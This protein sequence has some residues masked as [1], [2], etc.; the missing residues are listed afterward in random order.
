MGNLLRFSPPRGIWDRS[1]QGPRIGVTGCREEGLCRRDLDDL[2]EIHDDDA[3]RQHPH[4]IEVVGDEEVA[5]RQPFAEIGQQSEDDGLDRHIERRC[6]L[7]QDQERGLDR[8][9]ACDPDA[10]ALAA[11]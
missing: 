3:H 4:H 7:V 10:R 2:A 11:G 9:G 8:N 1:D 5:H 6:R